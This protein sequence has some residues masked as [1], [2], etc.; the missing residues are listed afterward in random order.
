MN[1][2]ALKHNLNAGVQWSF[3]THGPMQTSA[4]R[5]A[6]LVACCKQCTTS[7]RWPARAEH[8]MKT[9]PLHKPITQIPDNG[10]RKNG[11]KCHLWHEMTNGLSVHYNYILLRIWSFLCI[12]N[13]HMHKL[14]AATW[15]MMWFM[16][17]SALKKGA[18][19]NNV[20]EPPVTAKRKLSK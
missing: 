18:E 9:F 3:G 1:A 2:P 16:F 8:A 5:E 7:V 20:D 13:Q 17:F 19:K 15:N 11:T 4:A 14:I 10:D 6:L 12:S